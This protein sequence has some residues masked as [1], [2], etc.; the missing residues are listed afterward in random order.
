MTEALYGL[1]GALGGA[2]I[3]S[4]AAYW[5]PLQMQR[6][7][8]AADAERTEATRREAETEREAARQA[9]VGRAEAARQEAEAERELA[10][11]QADQLQETVRSLWQVQR[12]EAAA[13]QARARREQEITRIIAMRTT[14]R[15]WADLLSRSI[16]DL[17]LGRSVDVE[18]FDA[19]VS[20]ARSKTQSALDHALHDG[21]WIS[22]SSYGFPP[23]SRNQ[24]R[25]EQPRILAALGQVTA[26]TRAAAIKAEPL[27]SAQ[28]EQLRLALDRADEA[29]GTLSG[30]LL[31]RLEDVMGVTVIGEPEYLV[32]FQ[33][34]ALP[35]QS[36]DGAPPSELAADNNQSHVH[37]LMARGA[38]AQAERLAAQGDE[39]GALERAETAI[40][41]LTTLL[42]LPR[43][44]RQAAAADVL[45]VGDRA[46]SVLEDLEQHE[47]ADLLRNRLSEAEPWLST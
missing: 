40:E 14:T 9:E 46:L 15:A 33:A 16:Q 28:T 7:A 43:S 17:E 36:R 11:Q 21:V 2:L 35:G 23:N 41:L 31:N 38:I 29:R 47:S 5:G 34:R 27:S 44:V 8:F 12:E 22:Q 19:E 37:Y 42:R 30:A 3:T 32:A 26:L 10:R 20:V 39:S 4:A 45:A 13:N 24:R 1:L 6:R 18:Q 25:V